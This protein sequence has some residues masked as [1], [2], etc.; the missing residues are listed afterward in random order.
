MRAGEFAMQTRIRKTAADAAL[1]VTETE[2][3]RQLAAAAGSEAFQHRDPV[4]HVTEAFQQSFDQIGRKHAR[5]LAE[6]AN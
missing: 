2:T 4:Y 1:P 6:A 5:E 3:R